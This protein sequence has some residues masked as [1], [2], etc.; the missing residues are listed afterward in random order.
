MRIRILRARTFMPPG[1]RIT[2]R[3][4]PVGL[5]VTVKRAWG[6]ALV[7]WGDAEE[8]TAPARKPAKA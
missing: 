2:I 8:I 4:Y 5:E 7:A 6:D 3:Y 1:E